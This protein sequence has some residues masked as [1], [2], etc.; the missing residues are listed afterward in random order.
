MQYFFKFK[1]TCEVIKTKEEYSEPGYEFV[2]STYMNTTCIQRQACDPSF[3]ENS[4]RK[5][6]RQL[7]L[8]STF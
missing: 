7:T 4:D 5:Q 6:V 8:L 3:N 2:P 1:V